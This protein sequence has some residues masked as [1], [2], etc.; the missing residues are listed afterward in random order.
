MSAIVAALAVAVA[1]TVALE[2]CGNRGPLYLPTVPPLPPKPAEETVQP[3][4]R[5]A[6]G[7][8]AASSVDAN[9]APESEGTPLELAPVDKLSTPKSGA[10][11]PSS[12]S[13]ASG[14]AVDQ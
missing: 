11:S 14:S 13:P 5:A 9:P 7:A 1:G 6:S 12:A 3:P 2:G 8:E 4:Q 10:K